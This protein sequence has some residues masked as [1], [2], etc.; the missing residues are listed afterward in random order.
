[1]FSANIGETMRQS[2]GA[3]RSVDGRHVLRRNGAGNRPGLGANGRVEVRHW[4]RTYDVSEDTIRR[5]L[6]LLADHGLVQR[7]RRRGRLAHNRHTCR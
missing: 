3:A 1:M 2:D 6:R 5:D 7:P 4:R